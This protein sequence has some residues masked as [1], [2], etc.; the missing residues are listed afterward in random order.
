MRYNYTE[1]VIRYCTVLCRLSSPSIITIESEAIAPNLRT[2]G[3][4]LGGVHVFV[5]VCLRMLEAR[6]LLQSDYIEN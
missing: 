2:D 5:A 3:I 1:R 4:R 6:R